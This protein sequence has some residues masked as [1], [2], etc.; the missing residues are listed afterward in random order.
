MNAE[1]VDF[2]ED[3]SYGMIRTEV[4]CKN[5]G[6]HLGHVFPGGPRPSGQTFCM[7]SASLKL[8]PKGSKDS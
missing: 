1:K 7:N 3:R 8:R 6:G 5:C 4:T 2:H